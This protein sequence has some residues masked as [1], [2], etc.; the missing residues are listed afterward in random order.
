MKSRLATAMLVLLSCASVIY[1]ARGPCVLGLSGYST[2][3]IECLFP[4]CECGGAFTVYS[5]LELCAA[6]NESTCTYIDVPLVTNYYANGD[7]GWIIICLGSCSDDI[8]QGVE[9][10]GGKQC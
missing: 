2:S 7:C 6:Q 3:S 9:T 8:G 4:T 1:A 5:T 10:P